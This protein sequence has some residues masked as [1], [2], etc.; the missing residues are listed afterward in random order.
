MSASLKPNFAD[1]E[2]AFDILH[3]DGKPF[4]VRVPFPNGGVAAA[5][6]RP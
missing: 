1:V 5:G 4:E 3:A 6:E 2:K